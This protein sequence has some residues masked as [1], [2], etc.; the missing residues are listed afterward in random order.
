[1]AQSRTNK[2]DNARRGAFLD[3]DG[4]L[5]MDTGF[6]NDP[7]ELVLVPGADAAV[8]RLNDVGFA[9]L[10]VSN[11]SGVARGMFDLD[12]VDRFNRALADKIAEAGGRIDGFYVCP[13]HPDSV[14]DQFR[15]PD[16]PDRKP[17]PGMILRGLSEHGLDPAQSFMIGDKESDVEAAYRAGITGYRFEGG[18]LDHTVRSVLAEP[19][20]GVR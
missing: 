20:F 18:S 17:N 11:Q 16:H 2:A 7:A 13:Y 4:V 19:P 14:V 5:N 12:A 8:R 1:M 3:R 6:P 15:H 10:V 9:V